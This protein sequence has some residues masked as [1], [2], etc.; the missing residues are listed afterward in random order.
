MSNSQQ[1]M[2]IGIGYFHNSTISLVIGKLPVRA[3]HGNIH[4]DKLGHGL[5]T[6]GF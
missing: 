5:E 4:G 3:A 6:L 1:S 2:G